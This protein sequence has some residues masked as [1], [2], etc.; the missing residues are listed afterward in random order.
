MGEREAV[1]EAGGVLR[2]EAVKVLVEVPALVRELEDVTEREDGEGDAGDQ[3][4]VEVGA[5][6]GERVKVAL[7]ARASVSVRVSVGAAVA[8]RERV[9]VQEGTNEEVAVTVGA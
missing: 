1:G 7:A 3:L 4:G 8:V 5:A 2:A 6:V 9:C